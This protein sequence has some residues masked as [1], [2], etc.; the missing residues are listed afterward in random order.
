MKAPINPFLINRYISKDY[1]CDRTDELDMLLRNT[2]NG[3]NTTLISSRRLGK[4]GLIYRFFELLREKEI[5]KYVYIDILATQ[6]FTDFTN[7]LAEAIFTKFPIKSTIGSRLLKSLQGLRPSFIFDE[8]TGV[9]QIQFHYQNEGD[10][11]MTLQKIL[12]FIDQQNLPLVIAIDEFQQI[13]EYPEKN[14]EAFLR[15][16]I[17]QMKSV[18]FI[19]SGSKKHTLMDIFSN[20]KRP[21]YASSQFIHLDRINRMVYRSFI[22]NT[23]NKFNKQIDEPALD[24]VLNWTTGYT[25]Y[26]QALC[27]RLFNYKKID[28]NLVKSECDLLLK[29]QE[30]IF[31]Q[32]RK[33]LTIK[34]WEFLIA[35]AKEGTVEQVY[36]KDFIMKYKL[37]SS[38]SVR[39]IIN[40][41]IDKEMILEEN[42]SKGTIYSVYNIFLMRWLER[43]Y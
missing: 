22:L 4:T 34:Q 8:L 13:A 31:F 21:F 40:S 12:N 30:P 25:Y 35:M 32:Y 23:F 10:K 14:M 15:S 7:Q 41:L 42:T 6:C 18:N 27:N 36:S 37:G 38:S 16:T 28:V 11:E 17:Q 43:I 1:F 29:E 3:I 19:F 20:V 39:R 26:T 33:L 2:K 9:P 24:Y 5:I